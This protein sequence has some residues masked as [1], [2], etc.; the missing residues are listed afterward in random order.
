MINLTLELTNK[1][2]YQK[3]LL[4]L[5]VELFP[6][7]MVIPTDLGLVFISHPDQYGFSDVEFFQRF[8]RKENGEWVEYY[9][10]TFFYEGKKYRYKRNRNLY[11]KKDKPIVVE[12]GGC[13]DCR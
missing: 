9:I 6:N 7:E 12:V 5:S 10:D 11:N 4:D 8:K 3:K 13:N 2:T 1:K